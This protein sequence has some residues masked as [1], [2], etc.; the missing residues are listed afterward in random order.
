MMETHLQSCSFGTD[1]LQRLLI[2]AFGWQCNT[3]AIYY[4]QCNKYRFW[5]LNRICIERQTGERWNAQM[6][7][8]AEC[9]TRMQTNRGEKDCPHLRLRLELDTQIFAGID[10]GNTKQLPS[11]ALHL[12]MLQI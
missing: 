1:F 4:T 6:D 8:L 3:L 9:E 7:A 11:A 5:I 10:P 12:A 2:P